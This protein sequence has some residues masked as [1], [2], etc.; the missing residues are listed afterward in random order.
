MADPQEQETATAE[1]STAIP[2]DFQRAPGTDPQ[3]DA[4]EDVPQTTE[5]IA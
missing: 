1:E 3:E 4:K 2:E 5:V